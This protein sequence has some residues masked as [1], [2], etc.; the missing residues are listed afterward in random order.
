[1]FLAFLQRH[2]GLREFVPQTNNFVLFDAFFEGVLSG[3]WG[4]AA[5]ALP[6]QPTPSQ[7][8]APPPPPP[9]PQAQPTPEHALQ[10]PA[11]WQPPPQRL[12]SQQLQQASQVLSQQQQTPQRPASASTPSAGWAPPPPPQSAAGGGWAAR[13]TPPQQQQG[14]RS[15]TPRGGSGAP[16]PAPAPAPAP[17]APTP[18]SGA[19]FFSSSARGAPAGA[20]GGFSGGSSGSGG[21]WGDAAPPHA[22]PPPPPPAA[23]PDG[24]L[25]DHFRVLR[26]TG[27][28][29]PAPAAAGPLTG[30]SAAAW[31]ASPAARAPPGRR[32]APGAGHQWTGGGGGETSP[33]DLARV[34][35]GGRGGGGAEVPH[36]LRGSTLDLETRGSTHALARKARLAVG[37]P[38]SDPYLSSAAAAA[39]VSPTRLR[40]RPF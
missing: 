21:G 18:A 19:P 29:G 16:P 15:G 12:Q 14:H 9:P 37:R 28:G 26:M 11:H 34:F 40:D 7:P 8:R 3:E 10:Y 17:A 31:G 23:P 39:G 22:P 1:M 2:F 36:A 27:A 25:A 32:A 35:E 20:W 13:P 38:S 4:A 24:T 6:P 5:P 30:V 33:L